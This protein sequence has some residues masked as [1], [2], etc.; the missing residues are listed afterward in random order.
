MSEEATVAD[1][2][3]EPE[4]NET[5]ESSSESGGINIESVSDQIGADLFGKAMP[6]ESEEVDEQEAEPEEEADA[7]EDTDEEQEAEPEVEKLDRPA[8]WKKDMQGTWDAMTPEAQKYVLHREEQMKQGL[9]ID[10]EDS[11][12]GRSIRDVMTPYAQ[13]LKQAGINEA[14]AVKRLLDGHMTLVNANPEQ[15]KAYFMKMAQDYGVTLGE[16][17]ETQAADPKITMLEH[18]LQQLTGYI[19]KQQQRELENTQ[20]QIYTQVEEFASTH[21]HFDELA[22]PISKFIDAGFE[23][24]EAYQAAVRTSPVHFQKELDRIQQETA[25]KLKAEAKKQ[26]EKVKQ[27]TSVNVKNRD[28]GKAPTAPTGSMDDTLRETYREINRN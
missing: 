16:A 23:L 20:N 22:E 10:R 15:R 28:H 25:A 2:V 13:Q 8:S 17:G 18:Q 4:A 14:T 6:E 19:S 21:P 11:N 12:L 9:A 5:T 7:E 27:A 26:A 1:S 24:E 3:S